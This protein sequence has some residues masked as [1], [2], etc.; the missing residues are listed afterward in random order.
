M[1]TFLL[2]CFLIIEAS[3]CRGQETLTAQ[4]KHN[5]ILSIDQHKI[6]ELKRGYF[7]EHKYHLISVTVKLNNNSNET[8]K[9]LRMSCGID[10]IYKTNSK[11]VMLQRSVCQSNIPVEV[12][13]DPHHNYEIK[14]P[15]LVKKG[16]QTHNFKF[17]MGMALIQPT[18]DPSQDFLRI[19]YAYKLADDKLLW[20]NEVEVLLSN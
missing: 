7:N 14:L 16:Q 19:V 8:L 3:I 17:K 9:F 20:S 4:D 5:Y 13:V 6:I 11:D 12:T 10:E 18:Y 1:K 2:F 15:V